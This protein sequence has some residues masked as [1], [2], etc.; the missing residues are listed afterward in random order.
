MVC[1]GH[2]L[3]SSTYLIVKEAIDIKTGKY[4]AC[5]VINKKLMEGMEHMVHNEVAV[6]K[7][8]S[9]GHPNIITLH[10]YFKTAHNLYLCFNLCTGDELFD[11]V[12][13][14]GQYT[15]ADAARLICTIFG[16]I[17]YI[18]DCGIVHCNLK[19]EN[20]LFHSKPEKT[21]EIIIT[22]FRFS[23][24]MPDSKLS[25]LMEVCGTP[26]VSNLLSRTD[27]GKPIDVWAMGVITYFLLA[28]Y[29]PFNHDTLRQEMEAIIVGDYCFE[30][31]KS[32]DTSQTALH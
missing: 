16:A 18:H 21:S 15:K 13:A 4:Y 14:R 27:H 12:C 29:E 28:G 25:M 26:G 17:K 19:A 31:G 22:D 1:T 11:S 20:L 10:D 3:G 9:I 24:V 2:T 32:L 8:V 6:L 30:S 23:H 7:R 5:K